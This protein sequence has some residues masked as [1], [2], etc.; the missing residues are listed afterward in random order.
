MQHVLKMQQISLLPKYIKLI[1]RGVYL[2][3]MCVCEWRLSCTRPLTLVHYVS[4]HC[5][6]FPSFLMIY[7]PSNGL[8][9]VSFYAQLDADF[10]SCQYEMYLR[11]QNNLV[12]VQN[13]TLMTL[14]IN[15]WS[16]FI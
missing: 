11:Q 2:M 15:V 16:E 6:N 13:I 4:L 8:Q 12:N 3:C 14:Q 5:F 1:S 10:P 9:C 7:G